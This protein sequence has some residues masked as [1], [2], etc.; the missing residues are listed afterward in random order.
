MS[1]YY[2]TSSNVTRDNYELLRLRTGFRNFMDFE[3]FELD[4]SG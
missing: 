1:M 2:D 3:E 4:A